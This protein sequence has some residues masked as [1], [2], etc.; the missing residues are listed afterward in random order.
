[1]SLF[2]KFVCYP[3]YCQIITEHAAC[4]AQKHIPNATGKHYVSPSRIQRKQSAQ[5]DRAA[6]G[7]RSLQE[8]AF[9]RGSLTRFHEVALSNQATGLSPYGFTR[10]AKEADI[11]GKQGA[12]QSLREEGSHKSS[13]FSLFTL[14]HHTTEYKTQHMFFL[15]QEQ[16]R[17]CTV[18]L[19]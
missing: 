11:K 14:G 2:P 13:F 6:Q 8:A 3:E 9:T 18:N 5:S 4:A 12:D 10:Y 7:N 15:Y 1:M 19:P 17:N 16:R